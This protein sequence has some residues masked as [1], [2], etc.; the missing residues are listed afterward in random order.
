MPVDLTAD[1]TLCERRDERCLRRGQ[2]LRDGGA[3]TRRAGEPV[4][5]IEQI[6]DRRN[7]DRPH[8]YAHDERHLLPPRRRVDEL[9]GL[10]VLQVVVR[11]RGD[12]QQHGGD[13]ERVGHEL[14]VQRRAGTLRDGQHDQRR[15][16]DRENRQAR[17][18]AVGR[19]DQARHVAARGR[20]E[21]T[22]D[23]D[24]DDRGG[25]HRRRQRR[26]RSAGKKGP[27]QNAQRHQAQKA[28]QADEPDR[29]ILLG[30]RQVC[31]LAASPPPR[32]EHRGGDAGR[33][34]PNQTPQ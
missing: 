33:D 27:Q 4:G 7:D 3:G 5:V 12:A 14:H 16:D 29:K 20:D 22:R 2:R 10:E 11:D 17:D 15:A 9:S 30:P 34:R 6:E 18:R 23:H 32:G 19:A 21:K 31:S 25:R 8:H 26:E 24:V 13:H 28:D 1:H